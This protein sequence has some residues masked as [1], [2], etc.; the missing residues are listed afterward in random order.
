[1][2]GNVP[3][4]GTQ[5]IEPLVDVPSPMASVR[6]PRACGVGMTVGLIM[7]AATTFQVRAADP[8]AEGVRTTDPLTP[9][10]QQK[11]FKLPPGFEIQLVAAEPQIRKPM[12]MAF[13]LQ[14]RLW[15]SE[16]RE[17]PFA[18]P[19]DQ[20]ARDSIRVFSDFDEKGRAR[21]MT[22]F[23]DGLNIPIGI[24]PYRDGVIAWSIPN[25]WFFR[26]T[27]GD[28]KADRRE[29]WFGP[30]G[31]ERDTHGNIAS[32]KRGFD[33]WLY[34][35]HGFNNNTTFRARDGS[36]IVLNSGNTYRFRVDGS[37]V[38]PHTWGQ[39]N[40]FGTAWDPSGNLYTSDCHSSPMYQL[41]AGGYYPS[42]GKPHDGLGFAPSMMEHAHGST[43]IDGMLYYADRLWP[44][45]FHENAF[46]GNV[47]TSRLNRDRLEFT[48]SSP[49]AVELPDFLA[50]DDP[51]FRP[52]DNQL[53]P[54]GAVYV[55]DF[56]NRII[57]HYEVPLLHPGR[58]RERGRIWRIVY[59]GSDGK[60]ALHRRTLDLGTASA[61]ALAQELADPNLTWRLQAQNEL[62]DRFGSAAIVPM[63]RAMDAPGA[64]AFVHAHGLWALYR[65][66]GL[67]LSRLARAARHPDQLVRVHA[68]RVLTEMKDWTSD[69]G[70]LAL[71]GLKDAHALVQRCAV[72]ALGK[73]PSLESLESVL[74]LAEK[75]PSGDTHLNYVIRKAIRD[76]L[77]SE[78]I[79]RQ[80]SLETRS[81]SSI[82]RI[83]ESVLG[84][85]T[86]DS[87][88]LALQTASVWGPEQ[89]SKWMESLRHAA[90]YAPLADLGALAD[91]ASRK[92]GSD[93]DA[94]WEL[95]QMVDQGMKQRGGEVP[96]GMR[97]WSVGLARRLAQSLG[98]SEGSWWNVP[99][100][101]AT[102][103]TNPWGFEERP[104][105]D[106]VRARL[107]SSLPSGEAL[108]GIFRSRSFRAPGKLSFFLAGH[109][110]PPGQGPQGKNLARLKRS[111]NHEEL[112]RAPAPR[113][114]QA[115]RVEWDL[116]KVQ[117]EEV[118]FEIVDGDTG[119]AYAWIA[120]GR[121]E[122]EVSPWP[123][124]APSVS[125]ARQQVAAEIAREADLAEFD[126]ILDRWIKD[127]ATEIGP[128]VAAAQ[129]LAAKRSLPLLRTAA[130]AA[131][132]PAMPASARIRIAAEVLPA[133]GENLQ[134]WS[135]EFWK[136]APHR[137]Q[138]RLASALAGNLPPA[139]TIERIRAGGMPSVLL[140]E[141][142]VRDRLLARAT[143]SEKKEIQDWVAK[144]P[145]V[146]AARAQLI[147]LRRR[148]FD[149]AK[150][151]KSKGAELFAQNCKVC[152][153]LGQEGGLIGPQLDGIGNRGLERL[154]EDVLD[155]NRN[156]DRAFRSRVI[157]L[158]DGEVTTGLF[159]R[160]EGELVVVADSSGREISIP[161]ARIQSMTESES[162]LMP[163]N[164]GEA[165]P[166]GALAD[167]LA[168][169]LDQRE[170]K[171]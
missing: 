69:A 134:A 137:A 88:R 132:D 22:V 74:A 148:S 104:C 68:M 98:S 125:S 158:K 164:F 128:R 141:P 54:D 124:R 15:V 156:V 33:G 118:Y 78:T 97:G 127:P 142:V 154:L 117:G 42:F 101:D 139:T 41:L 11:R 113:N 96:A 49:K 147:E 70:Q 26:D 136:T 8:F 52:V 167:L 30:L 107:I 81:P 57:G 157:A 119:G 55:A 80:L 76:H 43:A 60:P 64:N 62:C 160:E 9:E 133:L 37:R 73:H 135:G 159:R 10:E 51:W 145:P 79:V 105:A 85:K 45:E 3:F 46:V 35:T 143:E 56:Y 77:L 24:Y 14:G 18:A 165:F 19:L 90:R 95:Y 29:Q 151:V 155:T 86:E 110:G 67:E 89:K 163:D 66:G 102:V 153:R 91:L 39:V 111:S 31:W 84:A 131:G 168:F 121:V 44:E 123:V 5:T 13:D 17:Y 144:N 115:R 83:A 75:V 32:F 82:A 152:H 146:N 140:S 4:A 114:D 63:R 94:E 28:G 112:F 25:I 47:M 103:L 93:M 72:E 126:V 1:M 116:S 40:P 170:V 92:F 7:L 20:P 34:G 50:S 65:V 36:S 38:E 58:D 59:R 166:E 161:K 2:K 53:G 120:F 138:V 169:L 162:S 106:G 109:D 6:I 71:E 130:E 150:A 23:V 100:V 171:H 129:A 99:Q 27:D 21:K 16:S 48:G 12:N 149:A 87:G 108:T 122:P 61:A